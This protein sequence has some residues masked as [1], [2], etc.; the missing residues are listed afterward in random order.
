MNKT[1]EQFEALRNAVK[2]QKMD[3]LEVRLHIHNDKR[4]SHDFILVLGNTSISPI[5]NYDLMNHF[6]LG[7]KKAK[8]I[9]SNNKI[10]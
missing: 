2:S 10:I 9:F 3:D 6:I 4:K 7:F 8:N 1:E 5:L